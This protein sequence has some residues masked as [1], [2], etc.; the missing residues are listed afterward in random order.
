MVCSQS[1]KAC[2]C[3]TCAYKPMAAQKRW[4]ELSVQVW[5]KK[6]LLLRVE[7]FLMAS[8]PR[9]GQGRGPLPGPLEY[10]SPDGENAIMNRENRPKA[11]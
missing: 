11:R 1:E 3:R 7:I 8:L 5:H 9:P 10:V 6:L 4:G 2:P